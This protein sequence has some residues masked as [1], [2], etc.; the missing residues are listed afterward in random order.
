M[1]L[2]AM[3]VDLETKQDSL[4]LMSS[5]IGKL[6]HWAQQN[7]EALYSLTSVTQLLDLVRYSFVIKDYQSDNLNLLVELEQGNLDVP[8][9]TRKFNDY[10]SFWKSEISEK[11]G[12]YLYIMGLRSS[13]LRADL[14][15]AY[16]LG[17]FNSLSDLQLHVA[18]SIFCRLPSTS[19]GDSQ[20]QLQPTGPKASG[21]SKGSWKRHN[22]YPEGGH[23]QHFDKSNKLLVGASGSE[24]HGHG[25]SSPQA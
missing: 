9:Y 14:M 3:G 25:N 12:I 13:P 8:D 2:T 18:R 17:K 22:K 1:R 11:I 7:I 15:S 24:G 16:S 10:Y 23:P 4:T 5:F 21:S 20:R 19:R 6:G